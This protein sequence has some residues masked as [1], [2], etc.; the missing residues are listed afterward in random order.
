MERLRRD[1]DTFARDH[2]ITS[3][4]YR[5]DIICWVSDSTMSFSATSH[6]QKKTLKIRLEQLISSSAAQN[7]EESGETVPVLVFLKPFDVFHSPT[8]QLSL[9]FGKMHDVEISFDP[10]HCT[11]VSSYIEGSLELLDLQGS[12]LAEIELTAFRGP[13][14]LADTSQLSAL[15]CETGTSRVAPIALQNLSATDTNC[16][17]SIEA[18]PG[19]VEGIEEA[20]LLEETE[21]ILPS[22]TEISVDVIFGPTQA[23]VHSASLF[24]ETNEHENVSMLLRAQGGS[25][26]SF[27]SNVGTT[28]QRHQSIFLSA[29]LQEFADDHQEENDFSS[30]EEELGDLIEEGDEE[31]EEEVSDEM[32]K[33]LEGAPLEQ[34]EDESLS[35][36][37]KRMKRKIERRKRKREAAAKA[38]ATA[39]ISKNLVGIDFGIVQPGD[40]YRQVFQVGNKM[41]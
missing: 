9:E 24:I 21:L 39:T 15:W 40:T 2:A 30:D 11:D 18:M 35:E 14:L 8:L 22:F 13:W 34:G 38:K 5:D 31:E 4:A 41:V 33:L 1:G 12:P 23:G 25:Q 32:R 17:L 27:A 29:K 6:P 26:I 20:F 10:A 37:A 28:R 3:L 7:L 36:K 16:K 19:E